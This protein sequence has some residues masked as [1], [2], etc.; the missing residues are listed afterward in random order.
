MKRAMFVAAAVVFL[1]AGVFAQ[2]SKKVLET[3]RRNFD[4][5][6]LDVKIQIL[7]DASQ[8]ASA[9]DMGPLFHQ[10]LDFVV[11]NATLIPSDPRFRQL[12]ASATAYLAKFPYPPARGSLWKMY[13][14]DSD[15]TTLVNAAAALGK[16]GAGDAEIVGSMNR[17]LEAQNTLFASGKPIV[18]LQVIA[19]T[20]RAVG[21]L[22]DAG[23]F[24]PVFSAMTLGYSEEMRAVAREA[25][26][27]L[28]G[29][30]KDGLLVVVRTRPYA[31]KKA[32]LQMALE[33]DRLSEEQKG[34]IAELALDIGV[35][36]VAADA[37]GRAVLRELR[38]AA[39]RALGDRKWSRATSLLIEHLDAT[40][41][42]YDKGLADRRYLIEAVAALGA[43]GTHEAAVRIT[44][45]LLLVNS[46]TEKLKGYDEQVVLAMIA[47][48]GRLGDRVAFD[49]LMYTQ[50]LGYSAPV[51]KAAREALEKLK[52]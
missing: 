26:F 51:K 38:F 44:Q 11:D 28:K 9:A 3:F 15:T 30:L 46:Y 22:G 8:G 24:V 21:M 43:A 27:S 6:S 34:Q 32:A 14:I 41:G 49:D 40:V 31:E 17:W 35:R 1:A 10:A 48:L 42:E 33:S 20:L 7:Q 19:A 23:S 36:T 2:D 12:T 5:A 4:I 45:Y 29:D 13:V 18:S 37:P 25:L 50:Y 39:A 52:W 47:A 16:V